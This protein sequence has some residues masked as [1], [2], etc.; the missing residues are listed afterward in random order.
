MAQVAVNLDDFSPE[1]RNEF[2]RL[3]S[4]YFP[5]DFDQVLTELK[6]RRLLEN[7]LT[8]E[9]ILEEVA[10]FI[11]SDIA[12]Q[13]EYQELLAVLECTSREILPDRYAGLSRE[14]IVQR[15]QEIRATMG[16]F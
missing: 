6:R 12:R 16:M 10:D 3:T 8:T 7:E 15:V 1:Q 9:M 5:A 11:P 4:G 2:L 13:R 14:S